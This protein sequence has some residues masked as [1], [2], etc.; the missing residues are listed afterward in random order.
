M[1]GIHWLW[2][3]ITASFGVILLIILLFFTNSSIVNF[4]ANLAKTLLVFEGLI[5]I[6]LLSDI[7][8]FPNGAIIAGQPYFLPYDFSN[9]DGFFSY[10]TKLPLDLLLMGIHILRAIF[11]PFPAIWGLVFTF[12]VVSFFYLIQSSKFLKGSVIILLWLIAG[13]AFY[14]INLPVWEKELSDDL[15]AHIAA[16]LK[17]AV[18]PPSYPTLLS[19]IGLVNN[20]RTLAEEFFKT[21][22]RNS[23]KIE[24]VFR[25]SI[26]LIACAKTAGE[27]RPKDIAEKNL[28][29]AI[30]TD[31]YNNDAIEKLLHDYFRSKELKKCADS[32]AKMNSDECLIETINAVEKIHG[33]FE[34]AQAMIACA[35]ATGKLNSTKSFR[36]IIK[37]VDKIR[38]DAAEKK[39][40]SYDYFLAEVLK[41]CASAAVK[42]NCKDCLIAINNSAN[43]PGGF[44]ACAN[45]SAEL[46]CVECLKDIIKTTSKP[47]ACAFASAKLNC[48]ECLKDTINVAKNL[49]NHEKQY[50]V[51]E[52]RSWALMDC[53][54]AASMA[55]QN[56]IA[57]ETLIE[58]INTAKKIDNDYVLSMTLSRCS[59][60]AA[61][62]GQKR[63]AKRTLIKA[64]S[65][66]KNIDNNYNRTKAFVAC[67]QAAADVK[68][69]KC[70]IDIV[71]VSE[72]F[73][74]S[75]HKF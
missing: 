75:D 36:T 32:A 7:L 39:K 62:I 74:E 50:Y 1:L 3:A 45:A 46:N 73:K 26:S 49:K 68:C 29:N 2:L 43:A 25:R 64:T 54:E 60:V 15:P 58:A 23:E 13:Y 63:I 21:A 55:N 34:R 8:P 4:R 35:E 16:S 24:P 31:G 11:F 18:S 6:R 9:V 40:K 30:N 14:S 33:L 53:A 52:E 56:Q 20:Q 71:N 38:N 57:N 19:Q 65:I 72:Q 48:L 22:I 42:L 28:F 47:S 27:I 70:L 12:S 51:F 69:K 44:A 37:V 10:F 5:V 17:C 59:G 67:A 66:A 61:K 41:A